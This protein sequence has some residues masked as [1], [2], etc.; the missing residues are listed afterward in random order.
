M[1]VLMG[2]A[3]GVAGLLAPPAMA[4]GLSDI[5]A[6]NRCEA[7]VEGAVRP[8][9]STAFKQPYKIVC[10]FGLTD[11][12]IGEDHR[13]VCARVSRALGAPHRGIAEFM[14]IGAYEAHMEATAP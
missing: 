5:D 6:I 1:R 9:F 11:P 10:I 13:A 7:F 8:E 4:Q 3:M 14:C 2:L 12:V